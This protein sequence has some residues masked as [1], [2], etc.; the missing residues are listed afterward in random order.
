MSDLTTNVILFTCQWCSY[1]AADLAG[2]ERRRYPANTSILRLPCTGRVEEPHLLKAFENGADG[3]MVAGCLES[4]LDRPMIDGFL[5]VMS[6]AGEAVILL[7]IIDCNQGH[8]EPIWLVPAEQ[9]VLKVS[10]GCRWPM[11]FF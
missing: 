6:I 3:V 8:R 1:A 2:S 5:A 11:P 9:R 10:S 4:F 7:R